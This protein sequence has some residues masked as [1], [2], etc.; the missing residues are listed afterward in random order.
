LQST[1][2]ILGEDDYEFVQNFKSAKQLIQ[3]VHFLQERCTLNSVARHVRELRPYLVHLE[4][5]ATLLV[6]SV[7]A[8]SISLAC[9]WGVTYLLILVSKHGLN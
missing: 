6:V 4:A 2:D 1:R 5:F 9:V 3:E 7:G 8:E